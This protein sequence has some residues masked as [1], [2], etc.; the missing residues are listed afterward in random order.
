MTMGMARNLA[1]LL[2]GSGLVSLTSKVT[3]SLPNDNIAA[4]AASKLTGQVPDANANSGAI[5]QV[6]QATKTDTQ[7]I[8]VSGWTDLSGLSLNITPISTSSRILLIAQVQVGTNEV[9]SIDSG[10]GLYRSSTL[11]LQGDASGSRNRTTTGVG[12]RGR[13]EIVSN[14]IMYVDSPSSTS[15]TNYN[16]KLLRSGTD[17]TVQINRESDDGDSGGSFRTTSTLIAMEISG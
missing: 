9:L 3:G 17:G 11:I 1:S 13:Y 2:N 4:M 10:L 14:S 6:V 16:I 8:N 5:L 12:V 7:G 15:S